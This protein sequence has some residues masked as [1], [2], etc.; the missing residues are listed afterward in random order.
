[1]ANGAD[2]VI[3]TGAYTVESQRGWTVPVD[4][5]LQAGAP[6]LKKA[7]KIR[8]AI[9]KLN[10]GNFAKAV[11]RVR[12]MLSHGDKAS[13]SRDWNSIGGALSF[14]QRQLEL[15]HFLESSEQGAYRQRLCLPENIPQEVCEQAVK[16]ELQQRA[17]ELLWRFRKR[18]NLTVAE[19]I[20]AKCCPTRHSG[21]AT[22]A[23]T[24]A[25][26]A[27]PLLATPQVAEEAQEEGKGT[28][29]KACFLE[30]GTEVKAK[31]VDGSWYMACVLRVRSTEEDDEWLR[32]SELGGKAIRQLKRE[33]GCTRAAAV[34]LD[35]AAQVTQPLQELVSREIGARCFMVCRS[36][37]TS[38]A[39]LLAYMPGKV[40][41]TL[42]IQ[43]L[44][45]NLKLL[46]LQLLAS[47][48][49]QEP[50]RGGSLLVH[51]GHDLA[52]ELT[53]HFL[54]RSE[55]S[56][57]DMSQLPPDKLRWC[58]AGVPTGQSRKQK[59]PRRA[60]DLI[61]E[62]EVAGWVEEIN[63]EATVEEAIWT[64]RDKPEDDADDAV[65]IRLVHINDVYTMDNLPRL[66]KFLD[67]LGQH[68]FWRAGSRDVEVVKGPDDCESKDCCSGIR[69][70]NLVVCVG[71]DLLSPYPLS[72]LDKGMRHGILLQKADLACFG[73]HE[74]DIDLPSLKQRLQRWRERGG[75]WINTNMPELLQE[76]GLP[77]YASVV[78]LSRDG[79]SSRQLCLL[80][81]CTKDPSLYMAGEDFGTAI[82][83]GPDCNESVMEKAKELMAVHKDDPDAQK[84]DAVVAL[85][86]QDLALDVELAGGARSLGVLA[87][88]GGHDH[89]EY[90]DQHNGCVLLKTGMDA[91]RVGVIDLL[92]KKEKD[93]TP[94]IDFF[95]LIPL[96][97]FTTSKAVSRSV[98]KHMRKLWNLEEK[99]A[100]V[101]LAI[102]PDKPVMSSK[103]IRQKQTTLGSFLCSALR[104]E[105]QV[106]CVLFDGGNI[107]GDRD[108]IPNPEHYLGQRWIF[109]LSDLELELPWESGMV[110]IVLDGEQI[111]RAV[112]LSRTL[113]PG[114]GG[115][116]QT[117]DGIWVSE[118]DQA[119]VTHIAN[120]QW[121]KERKY[122]VGL[123]HSSLVGMNHNPVFEEWRKRHTSQIPKED[124][125]KF[126]KELLKKQLARR[127][128]DQLPEFHEMN[129]SRTGALSKE[130]VME[131]YKK[132]FPEG[133][134]AAVE[135][136]V[137]QLM[138]VADFGEAGELS[139]A[140]YESIFRLPTWVALNY[141]TK[142]QVG[143]HLQQ[144]SH[145]RRL[146]LPHG[147]A[148]SC[149]LQHASSLPNAFGT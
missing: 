31:S 45:L 81:V 49:S 104:D 125:G 73:N 92:W 50:S 97:N 2:V 9:T 56:Q 16:E 133:P 79:H 144:R 55:E 119:E 48:N 76:L 107:R 68:W 63:W 93:S 117:D 32:L 128:W 105:M 51:R 101:H 83:Y 78:G 28:K 147:A 40:K 143:G 71:G 70:E 112:R 122:R 106:D 77:E 17:Q 127:L 129:M 100:R 35:K 23:S 148:N 132:T 131:A 24:A 110:E 146:N 145:L 7:E 109:T 58:T 36:L 44:S 75:V 69:R 53:E 14:L 30:K 126:A 84:V 103:S 5:T 96:A 8:R 113:K 90:I 134:E 124:S 88:L 95:E 6:F 47:G 139:A 114:S 89:T 98:Q 25:Q 87:V 130:K 19:A 141:F 33:I 12:S 121:K 52:L 115:F 38:T 27:A 142:E 102:F 34:L 54:R 20:E 46:S 64:L 123:M 149:P 138:V 10:D 1:M 4:F 13:F 136:S 42:A 15:V 116:L 118:D 94:T 37:A 80:G 82:R 108:Y 72:T 85:T 61:G 11:G 120:E 74:A 43:R 57:S 18:V 66:R 111:A 91:Q 29:R 41:G 26:A 60:E 99:K 3:V 65:R 22:A 67:E 62:Q 21:T 140:S 135:P 137:D 59:P 39:W 86:H